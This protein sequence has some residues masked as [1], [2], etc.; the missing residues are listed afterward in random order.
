MNR[1]YNG[2]ETE[3][4]F[5]ANFVL[6]FDKAGCHS[7]NDAHFVVSGG[8]AECQSALSCCQNFRHWLHRVLK[9]NGTVSDDKVGIM[10]TLGFQRGLFVFLLLYSGV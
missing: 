3:S 8:I 5:D 10:T 9:T 7:C 1:N 2:T 6:I 4:C